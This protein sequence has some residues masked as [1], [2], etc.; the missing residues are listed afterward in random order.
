MTSLNNLNSSFDLAARIFKTEQT[1]KK[2]E[3][4]EKNE[5]KKSRFADDAQGIVGAAQPL[6]PA[7]K[8]RKARPEVSY[9]NAGM[10]KK[11]W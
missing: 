2:T 7:M 5:L 3:K 6:P 1:S 9:A 10:R 8:P 11:K 4:K